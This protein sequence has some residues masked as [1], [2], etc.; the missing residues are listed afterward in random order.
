MARMVGRE[1]G[2]AEAYADELLLR[3]G[4]EGYGADDLY[5]NLF[6]EDDEDDEDDDE[7]DEED[8]DDEDGFGGPSSWPSRVLQAERARE[9]MGRFAPLSGIGKAITSTVSSAAGLA[10][11][12]G[13]GL[14]ASGFNPWA[15]QPQVVLDQSAPSVVSDRQSLP[16]V[17]VADPSLAAQ[18]QSSPSISSQAEMRPTTAFGASFQ[19]GSV[20]PRDSVGREAIVRAR[21]EGAKELRE[22]ATSG[23]SPLVEDATAEP[24]LLSDG[25]IVEPVHGKLSMVSCFSCS[26]LPPSRYGA[27][28][29]G[30]V[31]C[32]DYG[33]ILVPSSDIPAVAGTERFG[34]VAALL[35]ALAPLAGTA[36]QLGGSS[37]MT[38][39]QA[40][41]QEATARASKVYERLKAQLEASRPASKAADSTQQ[42]QLQQTEKVSGIGG[43]LGGL[44][45]LEDLDLPEEFGADV[46]A[47]LDEDLD[48]LD[49][50]D[51]L[52]F[53][54]EDDDL[55]S[56]GRIVRVL[57]P[58]ARLR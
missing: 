7:D 41:A 29:N 36:A 13:Q 34:F 37:A 43:D 24:V 22:T 38:G 57:F 48:F 55:S 23:S 39:R 11:N 14:M 49:D 58:R 5:D 32:D 12:A 51:P 21:L 35:G 45:D 15:P 10:A 40:Q 18:A 26:R 20:S 52:P 2:E 3:F 44:D 4:D 30:C 19:R 17:Y 27:T 8:E 47:V 50:D 16:P 31:V 1:L 53:E 42:P 33:A 56:D 25:R 54:E 46:D 28:G 6:G 9:E